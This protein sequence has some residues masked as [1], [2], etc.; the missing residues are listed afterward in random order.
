MSANNDVVFDALKAA[1][2][3]HANFCIWR[4]IHLQEPM[5]DVLW[6]EGFALLTDGWS[7]N[8]HAASVCTSYDE[9]AGLEDIAEWF[10]KKALEAWK[11]GAEAAMNRKKR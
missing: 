6:L 9:R 7:A 11:F 5:T 2:I 1:S 10:K 3:A 4:I 8:A